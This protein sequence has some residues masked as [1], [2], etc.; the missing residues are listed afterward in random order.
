MQCVTSWHEG[1]SM[2]VYAEALLASSLT[3][4][5]PLQSFQEPMQGLSV[6]VIH[7]SPSLQRAEH[8]SH[9]FQTVLPCFQTGLPRLLCCLPCHFLE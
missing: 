4:F 9:C 1:K 7:L 5:M 8:D 2:T 3:Q 6:H